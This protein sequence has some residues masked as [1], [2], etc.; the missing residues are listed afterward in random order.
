MQAAVGVAQLA[1]LDG[2]IEERRANFA[3]LS[4]GLEDLQDVLLLPRATAN[5]EPAWFGFPVSVRPEAGFSRTDLVRHLDSQRIATR[6]LFAGNLLRQPAYEGL[7]CRAVSD[8]PNTDYVMHRTFWLGVY[9]GLTTDALDHVIDVIHRF[10]K[11]GGAG[12]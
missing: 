12:S 11:H 6:Q 10:V 5:S 8:L 7:A 3:H 2:F 1:K 9:P 4:R